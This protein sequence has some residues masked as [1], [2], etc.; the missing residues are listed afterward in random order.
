M[1]RFSLAVLLL[2]EQHI[3]SV[4]AYDPVFEQLL[5]CNAE[6]LLNQKMEE[7]FPGIAG[8]MHSGSGYINGQ[9][10]QYALRELSPD[11]QLLVFT[12]QL[13]SN[14]EIYQFTLDL[15]DVGVQIY[16]GDSTLMFLNAAS[17]EMSR[18]K[19]QDVLGKR[20]TSIYE[21][22][23]IQSTVLA[24]LSSHT[25]IYNKADSFTTLNGAQVT[26]L[27]TA[28]PFFDCKG[29]LDA[30]VN[31]EY[32]QRSIDRLV[33]TTQVIQKIIPGKSE[34][35]SATCK[36]YH[37]DDIVGHSQLLMD[38][39]N[40]AKMVAGQE[41]NVFIVGETGTGK[42]LFAQSIYSASRGRCFVSVNCS[43]ITEG[44]ADATLFGTVKGA[45]TG[46]V[47][48]EGLFAAADGGV[49]F[50][51]EINSL[52]LSTQARL[53]R[54]LQEGVYMKVGA[55]KESSCHVRVIASCNQDP[56]ELMQTGKLRQDLFFRLA[57]SVI[58][59]PSLR[60]R[61]D[62]LEEL[63]DHFLSYYSRKSRKPVHAISEK[64][65]SLL[66]QYNW[67]GNIRELK[68]VIEFAVN[69]SSGPR[70]EIHHLPGYIQ[71]RLH[72][73]HEDK[74]TG[75]LPLS[76]PNPQSL[77]QCLEH[78]ERELI[79]QSLHQSGYNITK[80]ADFLG[81]SRQSLQYKMKKYHFQS[82]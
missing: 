31:L 13:S 32:S 22:D 19:R 74:F 46:S 47:N 49:L 36:Y 51:D 33:S 15:M 30:V 14:E 82:L 34:R 71:N 58:R 72:Y 52:S 3:T 48:A 37:F 6:S 62:D 25:A 63:V 16:S 56:W 43:T 9:W 29:T 11:R 44:L 65:L 59:V 68:N 73:V 69:I 76:S 28:I 12:F 21:T 38:A 1:N 18:I 17:E 5:Q 10:V 70:I 24:T 20:L 50:L 81:L 35:A 42:E 26:V 77:A 64:V 39:V 79:K 27:N 75:E 61:M 78:Y 8:G 7:V 54:V 53:L 23:E 40:L 80:A 57:A 41:S 67:P 66:M 4:L 55:I 2:D 45:F 60:D